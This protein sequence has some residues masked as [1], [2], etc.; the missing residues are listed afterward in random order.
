MS[1]QRNK[2]NT[3]SDS[4]SNAN[5]SSNPENTSSPDSNDT[6]QIS[7]CYDNISKL[8]YGRDGLI[9]FLQ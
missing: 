6:E 7:E 1:S 2:F 5:T 3:K 8:V 4:S 9:V